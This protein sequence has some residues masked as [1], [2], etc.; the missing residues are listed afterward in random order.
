M[1]RVIRASNYRVRPEMLKCF[2]KLK[3]SE[4]AIKAYKQ[5]KLKEKLPDTTA[6]H[7]GKAGKPAKGEKHR[8]RMKMREMKA[9]KELDKELKD[10]QLEVDT[11][12][13]AR[14]QTEILNQVFAT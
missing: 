1:S 4:S 3:L 11:Q 2:F 6:T 13:L 8:S 9:N 14:R 5:Q 10:A 7:D 12:A